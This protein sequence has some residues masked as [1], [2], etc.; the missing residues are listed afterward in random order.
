MAVTKGT[1]NVAEWNWQTKDAGQQAEDVGEG[2][3]ALE[4]VIMA[5]DRAVKKEGS[6][7]MRSKSPG[8]ISST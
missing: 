8:A 3:S 5:M 2:A 6:Y 7:Y 1:D 4:K